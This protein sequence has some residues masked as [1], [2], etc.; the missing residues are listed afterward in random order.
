MC[1]YNCVSRWIGPAAHWMGDFLYPCSVKM[2]SSSWSRA[3]RALTKEFFSPQL[4][5]LSNV[6]KTNFPI[7]ISLS[8]FPYLSFAV[9]EIQAQMIGLWNGEETELILRVST[10]LKHA[11]W[12]YPCRYKQE[13][14]PTLKRWF[15]LSSWFNWVLE[16]LE[17]VALI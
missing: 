10:E 7:W 2:S 11:L 5:N 3:W 17:L 6:I 16:P 8:V 13:L 12:L 15:H 9:Q 1:E 4:K 14:Q